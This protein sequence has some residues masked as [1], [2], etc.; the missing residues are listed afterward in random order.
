MPGHRLRTEHRMM[1]DTVENV[2]TKFEENKNENE[3]QS[4]QIETDLK[5]PIQE[6]KHQSE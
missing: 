3:L 4:K 1:H 2:N 6:R 5:Y